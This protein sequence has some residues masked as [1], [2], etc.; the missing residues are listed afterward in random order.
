MRSIASSFYVTGGTL[1]SDAPS[2]VERRADR[3]LYEGLSRGELCYVLTARQMGKSSLMVRTAARLR[4]GGVAVV[5]LDLTT[6]G[7][8]LS[9]EQ[10]YDGLLVLVGQQLDLEDELE[11]FWRDHSRLSPLQRWMGALREVVL[12][13]I[14]GRVV[15]FVDEIDTVRSLPFSTDE[16]FAGIRACYNRRTE[17]PEFHRLTFCLLGVASPSD[18]IR[19]TRLTPFNIGRR[20][21]LNDFSDA[22]AAPLAAGLGRKASD[23]TKLLE[24]VLYWTGGHPYLTQR[25]CQAVADDAQI[26]RSEHVD[27][28]CEELFLSPR[29]RERDDNLLFVRERL[30]RSDTDLASLLDLYARVRRGRYSPERSRRGAGGVRDDET[31]PLVSLLRLSGITRPGRCEAGGGSSLQVHNRI[32]ARVFDREWITTHMPD[33]ELR[34]Q[35]A[36]YRRGLVRATAA[37]AGIL[38]VM[39]ALVLI[40]IDRARIAHRATAAEARERRVAE[41]RLYAADMNL[42]HQAWALGNVARAQELLEA[43]RPRPGREDVRGFEWRYLWTLCQGGALA[44]FRGHRGQVQS[45]AFSPDGRTLATAGSGERT[46]KLWDVAARRVIVTLSGHTSPVEGVT[47]SPD[48]KSL[49]TCSD[50]GTVQLWRLATRR[51]IAT[52]RGHKG[53]ALTVAFSP[54]GRT[55]ASCGA[56]RTVRL[57]NVAS[58]QAL[59]ALKGHQGWVAGVAFSP[60]GQTLASGSRDTTVKLWDVATRRNVATLRGH[61]G[62]VESVAFSP[63]GKSLASASQDGAVK[64]WD[65][66]G[67]PR[68]ASGPPT[69][70]SVVTLRGHSLE[71]FSVAFSPDGQTLASGGADGARTWD[72]AGRQPRAVLAGPGIYRVAFSPDGKTLAT[73]SGEGLVRLWE[74]TPRDRDVLWGDMARVWCVAISPDSKTLASSHQDGTVKLWD[75][76]SRQELATLRGHTGVVNGVAFSPDGK[77]LASEASPDQRTEGASELKVWDVAARREVATFRVTTAPFW[78]VPFSPDGKMLASGGPGKTVIL[79][80]VATGRKVATLQGHREPVNWVAFSPDGRMLASTSDDHTVR[81]W[82][83]ASRR[84]VRVLRGHTGWSSSVTFSPDGKILASG[85]GDSTVK[86]WEV[87]SGR[88]MATLRGHGQALSCVAFSP[89]G[90]TLASASWDA[91]VKLWNVAL[92]QEVATLQGHTGA[93]LSVAFAPDGRTLATGGSDLTIRLWR[94]APFAETDGPAGARVHQASR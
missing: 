12:A 44:T 46:V 32:Y 18:L 73:G 70:G 65:L 36:A 7:Q 17:D 47:F 24:R 68:G 69:Q 58:R 34:R 45:L 9:P 37:F 85:S 93:V 90:K 86:L 62:I 83:I 89:D 63:D 5:V 11:D 42:A 13:R 19:D 27:R 35:Q 80:D 33:A 88:E 56:D 87:A 75:L 29:A 55:L 84:E 41:G 22:E 74:I 92:Q 14:A 79:W 91:T 52:L 28:L 39:A 20:I 60:D 2:Y 94:A 76:T 23:G 38:V 82:E 8:N 81:L 31:N 1:R 6:V 43:H 64:L 40:A 78:S 61:T 50:D 59:T 26:G 15:I 16:F 30:L 51:P 77:T 67:R 57:W 53:L 48:G 25:L 72:A 21:E 4:E 71:V 49:A 10:W 3:D 54:D 66:T